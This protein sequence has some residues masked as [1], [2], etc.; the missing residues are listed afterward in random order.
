M[1]LGGDAFSKAATFQIKA[2]NEDD[3]S[4]I[5]I[6]SYKCYRSS[7]N[8]SDAV[9]SLTMAIDLFTKKG[10]FRR[11]ANFKFELGEILENDLNDYVKAIEAYETAGEWY[12]QD[13]SVALANKC[14]IKSADLKAL[15]G[16]YIEASDLYS[17]L[18]KNSIGNRLSEWSLKEYYL[19][20]GLCQLAA[21]DNVAATRT[22]Q[23]GQH[24]S[25]NFADSRE[26][27]LL[28]SLIDCVTEGDAEK[29][30]E[31]VFEFDKFSKLDKWKTTILLKIKDTISQAEDDLL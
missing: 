29:L 25:P 22:L 14:Y 21:T 27:T 15:N 8:S 2:G 10:Q 28:K 1:K 16:Q 12:S 19:K 7:G 20:K 18:I 23:E 3:A 6:D 5:F 26:A 4:N 24:D 13:Q 9:N 31:T 17:K 30:S 11:A